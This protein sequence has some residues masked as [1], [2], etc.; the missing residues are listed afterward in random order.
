MNL[1]FENAVENYRQFLQLK[2]KPQSVMKITNRIVN[3]IL[4]YFKNKN[5]YELTTLDCLNWQ[6]QIDS[7]NFKYS[8]KKTLYYCF[9]AFLNYCVKFHNLNENVL[10]KVGNFKNDEINDNGKVWTI[11]DFNNYIKV[12]DNQIYSTLFKFMYFTGCRLGEVLALTFDDINENV[13][14]INK[15]ITKEYYNGKRL[16][17][18]PKTKKS[19]RKISID[20]LLKSE[21][22]Q[23]R[24]YY[25]TKYNN[26]NNK[27]Y[28]FGG[29]KA[30]S[31]TT[32]T[33]RKNIYCS[34]ANVPQIKLHEFRHSHA[35]LLFKN[36]IPIE[37]ISKRLGHSTITMTMD[38][39]LKY[40]PR[41]EKRVINTLNALRQAS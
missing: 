3:N 8:Y 19:I 14:D 31:P 32:I 37:D 1:T 9:V 4:P 41:D 29:I 20:N 5:I 30:L 38:V 16:I 21:I 33:T 7:M 23:L 17:T 18:T 26:F 35:C 24:E 27:F 11:N 2:D 10:I 34:K 22:E 25:I 12:I 15:T 40:I 39:Y 36:N 6:M 28:I 13:I